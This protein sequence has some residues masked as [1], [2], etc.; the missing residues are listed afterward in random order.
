M[1]KARMHIHLENPK[2]Y[3]PLMLFFGCLFVL[4]GIG[5][6]SITANT[7]LYLA[8]LIMIAVSA[9]LWILE[10]VYCRKRH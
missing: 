6:E 5:I 2:T 8:G 1:A 10:M 9:G 7:S 3:P 4:F